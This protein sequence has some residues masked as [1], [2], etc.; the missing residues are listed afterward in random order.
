MLTTLWNQGSV[1]YVDHAAEYHFLVCMD[2]V[3]I[4]DESVNAMK[5]NTET[6]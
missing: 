3:N 4:L 1:D 2:Y 5:Q 6:Y